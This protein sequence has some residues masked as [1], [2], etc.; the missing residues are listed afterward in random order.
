MYIP[1]TFEGALQQCLSVTTGGT[2]GYYISGNDQYKFHLFTSSGDLIVDA[3][4]ISN[5]EIYVIGGGGG[6]ARGTANVTEAA[7]GGG[8]GVQYTTSGRLFKGTY[9]VIVGAGGAQQN[10]QNTNGNSGFTSSFN[11]ANIDLV[12]LGGT[13][14]QWG[15]GG[16]GGTSGNGFIGGLNTPSS[17]NG[18]GGGGSTA[19]GNNST[20]LKAGDGGAGTTINLAQYTFDYGCG[21]GG[22]APS[23]ADTPGFSCNGNQYGAGGEGNGNAGSGANTF[24]MGGGGGGNFGAAGGSG[25]VII[26][27][28]IY[29]YCKDYFNE[30]GSCGCD[31]VTIDISDNF[32]YYPARTGS[33]V[34]TP[35]GET[36]FVSSS[37]RAYFPETVCIASGSLLWYNWVG[38][39][40][41]V[42]VSQSTYV[43]DQNNNF[44]RCISASF[45]VE[46]CTTQ[47]V[48]T[49]SCS[50]ESIVTFYA[51]ASVQTAKYFPAHS[52]SFHFES[53]PA[54]NVRY[55]CVQ[56]GS[57]TQI[58]NSTFYPIQMSGSAGDGIIYYTASCD[59]TVFTASWN[60]VGSSL[61]IASM[62]YTQCNGALS[63]V[64]LTRNA[65]SGITNRYSSP[66]C[67]D[68][69]L[70]VTFT[71]G[72]SGP[73]PTMTAPSYGS[74]L[75]D[76]FSTASC[77]C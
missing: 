26:K 46:T 33:F 75:N 73:I 48:P 40:G 34:Y 43:Y 23:T 36:G 12:S 29:D 17:N 66:L 62:T 5:V 2:E 30:S 53:I 51:S 60:G 49:S 18:G 8:G 16:R 37:I 19:V 10:T 65:T 31:R 76:Y 25:S 59:N 4:A 56:S 39:D 77:G 6:G 1:L 24:G 13:G 21:G 41:G 47:S 32:D 52:S 15:S 7:G 57:I 20:S 64:T 27:Y 11:G 35:C 38:E 3:G 70:P 54:N 67:I 14:G 9:N 50:Q 45:G 22:Y 44:P 68:K 58:G 61:A 71:Y 55:R 42:I 69:T 74:C 28:R 63:Q 72:V